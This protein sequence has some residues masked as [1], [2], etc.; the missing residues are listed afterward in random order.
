MNKILVQN[1]PFKFTQNI[2]C[3]P[4]DSLEIYGLNINN[5]LYKNYF[6]NKPNVILLSSTHITSEIIHFIEDFY[7]DIKIYIYHYNSEKIENMLTVFQ[8]YNM[9][10]LCHT[11]AQSDNIIKIPDNLIND[12]LFNMDFDKQDKENGIV[13]F[14]DGLRTI[15]K[16]LEEN[17]YP[18]KILPLKMFNNPGTPHVQNLGPIDE[19]TKAELLKQYTHY[20][21]CQAMNDYSTE[22]GA[23]GCVRLSLSDLA[24]F[25]DVPYTEPDIKYTSYTQFIME[26][27]I[28]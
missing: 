5:N 28:S 21:S 25:Q 15:P 17:L 8:P 13:C 27:I 2:L 7:N 3:S 12:K 23:C 26:K 4:V 10:H 18:N 20:L 19:P 9:H 11:D 6:I 16:A 14:L 22:S 24:N 1:T